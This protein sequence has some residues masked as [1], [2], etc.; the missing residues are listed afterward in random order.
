MDACKNVEAVVVATEWSEFRE[1][2]WKSIHAGMDK[3]AFV[4]DG[5]LLLDAE[6]LRDIGFKVMAIGQG[7]RL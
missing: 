4:F 3:P 6:K 7:E 1:L 5:R 2:D